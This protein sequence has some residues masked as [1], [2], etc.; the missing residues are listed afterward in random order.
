MTTAVT[1]A[2]SAVEAY[3][4]RYS[5]GGW[6]YNYRREHLRLK[7]IVDSL[8]LKPGDAVL[9]I[10]CGEGFHSYVLYDLGF[11]VTGNDM[12][13]VGIKNAEARFPMIRFIQRN[14]FELCDILPHEHFDMILARGHS[15]Y[16]YE[17]TERNCKGW[18]VPENTRQIF[19]LLRPGGFFV[20]CIRTDFS[21]THYKDGVLNNTYQAYRDLFEPFGEIVLL[22]DAEGMPLANDEDARQSKNDIII[23]TKK[24]LSALR[25]ILH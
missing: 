9:E 21:G 18:N 10:G 8:G 5:Q 6:N 14:S 20:L 1:K 16:H 25:H 15:W 4:I 17:L 2:K 19:K 3:E 12:S 13:E 7:R 11:R 23:A 24:P 22:T